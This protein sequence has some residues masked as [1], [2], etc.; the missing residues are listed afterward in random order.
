MTHIAT[1]R[2]S[3]RAAGELLRQIFIAAAG[4]FRGSS[5]YQAGHRHRTQPAH[6][7]I[8]AR[9]ISGACPYGEEGVVGDRRANIQWVVDPLDGTLI[10][11]SSHILR[12]H[13]PWL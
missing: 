3:G 12:F 11:L 2:E 6:Y 9:P 1:R 5:R 10:F 4:Q 7:G 8:V 13:S